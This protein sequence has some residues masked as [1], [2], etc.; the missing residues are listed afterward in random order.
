MEFYN[1][2][3]RID[4]YLFN[5]HYPVPDLHIDDIERIDEEE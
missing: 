5:K 1:F 3:K 2:F 4:L